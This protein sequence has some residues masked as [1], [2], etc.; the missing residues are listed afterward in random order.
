MLTKKLRFRPP[1]MDETVNSISL[2]PDTE[3]EDSNAKEAVTDGLKSPGD[4]NNGS[5]TDE[6][7]AMALNDDAQDNNNSMS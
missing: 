5:L 6:V 2:R 1:K 3:M 7:G 4:N